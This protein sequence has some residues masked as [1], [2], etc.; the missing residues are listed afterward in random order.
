MNDK[1][2]TISGIADVD[3]LD[4]TKAKHITNAK[5]F[6]CNDEINNEKFNWKYRFDPE[7]LVDYDYS[8]C[9]YKKVMRLNIYE[10]DEMVECFYFSKEKVTDSNGNSLYYKD[11]FYP[12]VTMGG[13]VGYASEYNFIE[14]VDLIEN[15]NK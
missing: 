13:L 3:M 11:M 10:N 14:I 8:N 2:I 5:I 7:E 12:H 1:Q 9:I 6:T 4:L 15:Y